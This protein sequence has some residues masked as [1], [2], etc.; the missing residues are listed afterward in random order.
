[1]LNVEGSPTATAL[2]YATVNT[3]CGKVSGQMRSAGSWSHSLPKSKQAQSLTDP[4][5]RVYEEEMR[6]SV[7]EWY[8]SPHDAPAMF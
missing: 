3:L 2:I 7:S 6:L 8:E 1:M 5:W 4:V